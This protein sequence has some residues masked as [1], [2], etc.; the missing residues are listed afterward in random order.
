MNES[1][2]IELGMEIIAA[3]KADVYQT[4]IEDGRDMVLEDMDIP[5][6]KRS[7]HKQALFVANITFDK[8]KQ[9]TS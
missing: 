4:S 9:I 7:V 8:I 6:V 1:E 5:Y 2:K 3:M